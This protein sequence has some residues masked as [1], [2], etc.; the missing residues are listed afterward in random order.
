MYT[1]LIALDDFVCTQ[2]YRGRKI[3]TACRRLPCGG[4]LQLVQQY[5]GELRGAV[6]LANKNGLHSRIISFL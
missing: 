6:L 4:A 1:P 5:M 3:F 2:G